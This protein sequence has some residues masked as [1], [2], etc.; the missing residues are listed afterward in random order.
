MNAARRNHRLRTPGS[1]PPADSK[2]RVEE[3]ATTVDSEKIWQAV[4]A[5]IPAQKGFVRNSASAAHVLGVEG[6]NFKLGFAPGD[7]AT[8]DILGTQ[9]N[10]KFVETLLHE[11]TEKDWTLKLTVNEELASKSAVAAE[12]SLLMIS[13]TNH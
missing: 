11:I 1:P 12:D 8:M 3:K 13:K 7:K 10:R 9:A 5:K 6:R 2:T 4:L